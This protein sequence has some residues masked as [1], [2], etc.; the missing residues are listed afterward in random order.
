MLILDWPTGQAPT[1]TKW[2]TASWISLDSSA[3]IFSNSDVANNS[4]RS[5]Q[6]PLSL[7]ERLRQAMERHVVG[8]PLQLLFLTTTIATSVRGFFFPFDGFSPAHGVDILSLILLVLACLAFYRYRLAGG[9]R[10]TYVITAVLALYC[11]VFV[12]IMPLFKKVPALKGLAP[13]QSEPPFAVAQLGALL[14]LA[15][16]VIRAGIA[17]LSVESS[18]PRVTHFTTP[19]CV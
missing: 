10:R 11:D 9:W 5:F 14:L 13:T 19:S 15:P 4:V 16:L 6:N 7:P 18:G 17:R 2:L 1:G 3:V 12:P 8:P